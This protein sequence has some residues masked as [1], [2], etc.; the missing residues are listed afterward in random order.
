LLGPKYGLIRQELLN[1]ATSTLPW[2]VQLRS[3]Y[4][5]ISS[6]GGFLESDVVVLANPLNQDL[7][8]YVGHDVG[9]VVSPLVNAVAPATHL[10][11][12]K[13]PTPDAPL[14]REIPGATFNGEF[15]GFFVPGPTLTYWRFADFP[16]RTICG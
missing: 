2:A 1:V 5:T 16:H 10:I 11:C 8:D 13:F 3:L 15:R 6:M 4:D 9:L 12:L 14:A 7:S